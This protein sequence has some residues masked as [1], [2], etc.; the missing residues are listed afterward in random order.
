VVDSAR[1]PI[2]GAEVS[3]VRGLN[4]QIV[5]GTTDVFGMRELRVARDEDAYQV[6]VRRIGYE[7]GDRFFARPVSDTVALQI[8]L[9]RVAQQLTPMTVTENEDRT[10]KHYHLGADE[11]ASSTRPLYDAIDV[12]EKIR[13]E[14]MG[15]SGCGLSNVWVNGRRVIYPPPNPMALMRRGTPPAPAP[16]PKLVFEGDGS[17]GRAMPASPEQRVDEDV[18]SALASI[19][20][21]HILE[22]NYIDCYI[23]DPVH[24]KGSDNAVYVAL[25]PGIGFDP[26]IGSFVVD[27]ARTEKAN[28][29]PPI[30]MTL[31]DS[32]LGYRRRLLGVYNGTTGEPVAGAEVIDLASG[33]R[34]HTT[35]TGTVSLLY[36]PEGTNAIRIHRPGYRDEDMDVTIAPDKTAPI[37]VV[38]TPVP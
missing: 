22:I 32:V 20:P 37:T 3:V 13:P 34:A 12:L 5:S 6:V 36:L 1:A 35:V 19:K 7:R 28:A 33:L 8:N 23:A 26:G 31:P 25:K 2:A 11:I 30:R 17:S 27:T 29:L 16:P 38:L 15:S 21:E 10:R 9:N 18:W 24:K 4:T 14:M